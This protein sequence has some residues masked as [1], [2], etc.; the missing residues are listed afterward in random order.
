MSKPIAPPAAMCSRTDGIAA[1]LSCRLDEGALRENIEAASS[2]LG[3]GYHPVVLLTMAD[4]LTQP[5]GAWK[6]STPP[7]RWRRP[8]APR[9]ETEPGTS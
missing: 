6:R 7:A 9:L 2:H 1:W 5:E 4:R 3:I 8:F